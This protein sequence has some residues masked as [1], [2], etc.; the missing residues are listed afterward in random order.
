MAIAIDRIVAIAIIQRFKYRFH[1]EEIMTRFLPLN[2]KNRSVGPLACGVVLFLTVV[3]AAVLARGGDPIS[4]LHSLGGSFE[5]FDD[6]NE[7]HRL[8]ALAAEYTQKVKFEVAAEIGQVAVRFSENAFGDDHWLTREN[9]ALLQ[10]IE[11]WKSVAEPQQL[12]ADLAE[13][14]K[15][16]IEDYSEGDN[17]IAHDECDALLE[18]A[19]KT[20]GDES[21]G[22]GNE[23]TFCAR[24]CE[25]FKDYTYSDAYYSQAECLVKKLW[26]GIRRRYWNS[27]SN[28]AKRMLIAVNIAL[29]PRF[30]SKRSQYAP[31]I[32]VTPKH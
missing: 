25:Q 19:Q 17:E 7:G 32:T 22:Y 10:F 2:S 13:R 14:H 4:E 26:G 6:I 28:M 16:I 5:S 12:L 24:R 1:R 9:K 20:F 23:L 27:C 29:R 21:L 30:S 31:G 18:L 11:T 8:L 15:F 3:T